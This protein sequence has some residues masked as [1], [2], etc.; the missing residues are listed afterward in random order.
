[1]L[2][3]FPRLFRRGD[4]E[5]SEVATRGAPPMAVR[6]PRSSKQRALAQGRALL[7]RTAPAVSSSWRDPE[8]LSARDAGAGRHLVGGCRC[9]HFAATATATCKAQRPADAYVHSGPG[10][11][12]P[13]RRPERRRRCRRR[14]PEGEHR[15]AS[16]GE[17][18]NFLFFQFHHFGLRFG[19]NFGFQG[20]NWGFFF[21]KYLI[22]LLLIA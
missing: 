9:K 20:L 15:A 4:A 7:R 11:N 2:P 18:H 21:F 17:P 16:L 13:A 3:S 22:P 1:M 8:S 14:D 19:K 10:W 5:A 6:Q 12:L